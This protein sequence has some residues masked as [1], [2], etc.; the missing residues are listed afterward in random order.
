MFGLVFHN[1]Y[2]SVLTEHDSPQPFDIIYFEYKF[3]LVSME[4]VFIDMT[5]FKA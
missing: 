4:I 2:I 3:Y 5:K 1:S